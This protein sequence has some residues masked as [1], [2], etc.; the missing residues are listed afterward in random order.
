MIANLQRH[1]ILENLNNW[2]E[3]TKLK[4]TQ[5]SVFITIRSLHWL[6]DIRKSCCPS[7][8]GFRRKIGSSKVD[9]IF[10]SDKGSFQILFCGFFPQ[11]GGGGTPNIRQKIC[12]QIRFSAK[13]T[14]IQGQTT[15]SLTLY[16]LPLAL[17]DAQ[18]KTFLKSVFSEYSVTRATCQ[19]KA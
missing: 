3:N 6:I 2:L 17:S 16:N 12:L 9:H 7:C 13:K 4:Q 10:L 14:S 1:F 19:T 18:R 5:L 8:V 15:L 11:R